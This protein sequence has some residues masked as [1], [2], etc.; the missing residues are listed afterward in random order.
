MVIFYWLGARN[1]RAGVPEPYQEGCFTSRTRRPFLGTR[2]AAEDSRASD[3]IVIGELEHNLL[4]RMTILGK[5]N[6]ARTSLSKETDDL[7]VIN[8]LTRLIN[9]WHTSSV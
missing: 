2:S 8:A 5:V 6:M 3:H 1:A 7:V 4:P 9:S